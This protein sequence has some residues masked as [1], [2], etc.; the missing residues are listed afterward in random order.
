M[1]PSRSNMIRSVIKGTGSYIPP[2]T[3]KND[4]FLNHF[5][6]EKNGQAINKPNAILIRKLKEITGID[7]RRYANDDQVAS[8]LAYLSARNATESSGIDPETLDYIIVAH[9]FGDIRAGSNRVDM[10]PSIASRVKHL[11]QVK[12]PD[13]VAYDLPFGCPGWVEAMIQANYF[14]RSGDAKRCLVIGAETVSRVLD[15]HDRDSMLFSDGSGAVILEAATDTY[16]GIIAHKSRTFAGE[17][18]RLID[19]GN[20]FNADY[21]EPDNLLVKM[22]GRRV[23]E[24]AVSQVPALLKD[25]LDKNNLTISDVSKILVHQANEKMNAAILERVFHAYGISEIKTEIMPMTISWLGNSSVATVPTL[26][27]LVMKGQLAGHQ[28]YPGDKVVF[29]SV[30]AGMNVNGILYQF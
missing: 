10:V 1:L 16:S 4:F 9:N 20:S 25:L 27:D 13:C 19:M 17:D 23:Y 7:E 14:I 24:F 15:P 22:N 26:L 2:V 5:F 28:V 12:N 21:Q 3:I 30:G 6:F 18:N 29:A 8:D 11:L